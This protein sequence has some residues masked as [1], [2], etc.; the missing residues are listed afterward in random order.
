VLLVWYFNSLDWEITKTTSAFNYLT[1]VL[2]M[3]H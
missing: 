2:E 1:L 3:N